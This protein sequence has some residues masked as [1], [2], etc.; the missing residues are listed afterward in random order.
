M[1]RIPLPRPLS[2][3]RPALEAFYAG[4]GNDPALR[5][6]PVTRDLGKARRWLDAGGGALDG[7]VAKRL[8]GPYLPGERA[9]LK[10]KQQRSADCVVGGFRYERGAR[11]VGSLLLGLYDEVGRL[12]HVG[13]TATLHHLDREVLTRRLQDLIEPPG[14]TGNMPGGPSRW[15][16]ERSGEWQPLRPEL[17]VEWV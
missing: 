15:A 11:Q 16:T 8:D 1:G 17:V 2:Q 3:R 6:S 12:D 14:F 9:M 5:L 10:V 4:L 13:F 7:V